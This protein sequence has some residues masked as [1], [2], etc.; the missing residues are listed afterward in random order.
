MYVFNMLVTFVEQTTKNFKISARKQRIDFTIDEQL[1]IDGD[2]EPTKVIRQTV[3]RAEVQQ[4]NADKVCIS[5]RKKGGDPFVFHEQFRNM[6]DALASVID[7][8]WD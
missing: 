2:D 8:E 3:I 4:A 7:T 5:F 6:V 1:E